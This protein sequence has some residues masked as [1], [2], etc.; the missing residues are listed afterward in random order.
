MLLLEDGHCLP[1][2]TLAICQTNGGVESSAT[3]TSLETLRELVSAGLG[4]TLMP[5]LAAQFS[6]DSAAS[7]KYIPFSDQSFSRKVGLCWRKSSTR[8]QL[9]NEFSLSLGKY[10]AT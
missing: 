10:L 1:R 9:L 7:V 2:S 8:G 3:P 4:V 6:G 5:E